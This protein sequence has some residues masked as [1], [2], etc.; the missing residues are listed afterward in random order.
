[1][2]EIL[3]KK[4]STN[5][6]SP[7]KMSPH[8]TSHLIL[9]ENLSLDSHPLNPASHLSPRVLVVGGGVTGLVSAWVLLDRGYHVTIVAKEW[10]SWTSSQRLT[11][12][13]AGAL[14][15]WPPA[16]CGQHTDSISLGMFHPLCDLLRFGITKI[17]RTKKLPG[18]SKRWCMVSYRIWDTIASD[19][20]LSALSGVRMRRAS[21]LFPGSIEDDPVQLSKMREI[22]QSG[23]R[24]FI[25]D[26]CLMRVPGVNKDYGVSDSYEHLAPIID[27]DK[28]MG[29]LMQIVQ[30]KGARLMTEIIR[31]DLFTQEEEL[32]A[33]FGAD[34]I[35]NATGLGIDSTA[36]AGDKS[37]YPIHG[38]LIRVINDGTDF[39]VLNQAITMGAGAAHDE[40][41]IVFIVPRNDKI[42]LLGGIVQ[43]NK[44]ELDY[45]LDTPIMKRMRKRCEDVFPQLKGARVDP[46]YPIMQGLRPFRGSNVRVE[47]DSRQKRVSGIGRISRSIP[48]RIVH[49]YGHGGSGWSLAFGCAADV[50]DIV[51]EVL[52]DL[53]PV[54]V[55]MGDPAQE[56]VNT[57][58]MYKAML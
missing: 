23:I 14:W 20:D 31:G 40:N 5:S 57:S 32:L 39:P 50:A 10:A 17:I 43:P 6:A 51:D 48:S 45:N 30:A 41:Q 27:T 21:F 2:N 46:K 7:I 9:G 33:R 25:R 44:S 11:S 47:R 54:P 56:E 29:W 13:I 1:M 53:A 52:D 12:Q 18:H 3:W 15:E 19:H 35:V 28:A 58:Q 22:Q 34:A 49:S 26:R 36:T 42:L 37:C 4:L 38:A 24:G 8:R 16:V 55:N